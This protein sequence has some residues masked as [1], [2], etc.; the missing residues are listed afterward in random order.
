MDGAINVWD[1]KR[2]EEEEDAVLHD[3]KKMQP[4]IRIDIITFWH[5]KDGIFYEQNINKS[6]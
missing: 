4:Q 3:W 2:E 1:E 6:F 5:L